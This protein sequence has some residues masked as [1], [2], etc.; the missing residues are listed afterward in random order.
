MTG[1]NKMARVIEQVLEM[2]SGNEIWMGP[3]R[4]IL[5]HKS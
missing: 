5:A 2:K 1:K 4:L 3:I